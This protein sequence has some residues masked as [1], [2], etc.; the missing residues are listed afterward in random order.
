MINVLVSEVDLKSY[1]DGEGDGLNFR[2]ESL[3]DAQ[4]FITMSVQGGYYVC[5]Y[6][7]KEDA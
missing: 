3:D 4:S 5:I 7:L 2:F 6:Q 1:F